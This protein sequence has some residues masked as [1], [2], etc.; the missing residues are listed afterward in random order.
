MARYRSKPRVLHHIQ[1]SV[2][3]IFFFDMAEQQGALV[4]EACDVIV[5]RVDDLSASQID[6]VLVGHNC[7]VKTYSGV[8]RHPD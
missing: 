2:N 7:K 1:F 6:F 5:A 3:R 4:E 8:A